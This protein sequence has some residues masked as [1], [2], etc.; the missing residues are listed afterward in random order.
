MTYF[1]V[2]PMVLRSMLPETLQT[3]LAQEM[4]HELPQVK[5]IY[6]HLMLTQ[7]NSARHR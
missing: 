5:L 6:S 2:R 1:Q 4:C 7:F 3:E